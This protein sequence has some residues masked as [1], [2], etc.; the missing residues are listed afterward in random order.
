L[1][2]TFFRNRLLFWYV[3]ISGVSLVFDYVIFFVLIFMHLKVSLAATIGYMGGGII[4]YLFQSLLLFKNGWLSRRRG[5]EVA[6]Y[7]SSV[8]LGTIITYLVVAS[9]SFVFIS[10]EIVPKFIA[11]LVSF[12][13]VFVF[14]RR[15]VFRVADQ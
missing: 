12:S 7:A 13:L 2:K 10:S 9:L 15:I 6:L 14:R 4:A 3:L 8:L 5:L 11:T 1:Q